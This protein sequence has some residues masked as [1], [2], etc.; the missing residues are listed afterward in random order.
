M[1]MYSVSFA[2]LFCSLHVL[3]QTVKSKFQT[4]ISSGFH[5]LCPD[6]TVFFTYAPLSYTLVIIVKEGHLRHAPIIFWVHNNFVLLPQRGCQQFFNEAP[7]FWKFLDPSVHSIVETMFTLCSSN[8][9][10]TR[11]H[12]NPKS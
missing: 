10:Y 12:G 5:C 9:V 1:H 2:L 6:H 11:T 8:N 4:G 3:S 7:Q